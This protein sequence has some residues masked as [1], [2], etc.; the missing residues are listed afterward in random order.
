MAVKKKVIANI[1]DKPYFIKDNFVLYKND[2]LKILEQI[3]ENSIDMIFADPP[4]FL[5]S[6][7]FTCQ[8]GRMVSV[9]KGDWDLSNGL[10]RDFE[11]HL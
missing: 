4:Y 10:K 6:G 1:K 11:F 9:K 7:T 5:S 2:C 8:N 3:P